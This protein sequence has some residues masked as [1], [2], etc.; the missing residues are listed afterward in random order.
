MPYSEAT[1]GIILNTYVNHRTI[2]TNEGRCIR[3]VLQLI[4]ASK[5]THDNKVCRTVQ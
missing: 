4:V 5:K 3:K 2:L 1:D